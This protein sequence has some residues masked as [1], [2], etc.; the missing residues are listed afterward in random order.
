[1]SNDFY[2][3][4]R[5]DA[6]FTPT[7]HAVG[8][9]SEEDYHFSSLAGLMVH[10]LE[11]SRAED[12]LLLSRVC[13]DILGRLPFAEVDL[14]V[15]TLRP[16]RTIELVQVTASIGG[17]QV[18]TARAWYL[19]ESDTADAAACGAT[20]LPEPQECPVR[21]L[22]ELWGGGFVAQIEARQAV[23]W[24]PGRGA[25]WLTSPNRLVEGEEPVDVAE[26]FSLIDVANGIAP[27]QQPGGWVFPNVDLTVHLFR[28]PVGRWTGLDT[29]V[30]WG[31]SGI[32][33]TGSTLHDVRGP[34]GRAEQS[35]TLRR[36]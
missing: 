9:W 10:E 35:L 26:Y 8:A 13:F 3:R 29:T 12:G 18:I 4:R 19:L 30:T 11:R 25:T 34:V 33:I 22:S 32:G 2:F 15:E 17:R 6:T 28:R 24:R 21:D 36:L 23:E 31:E 27:R 14:E 5:G 7:E 16:G 1:M 20:P